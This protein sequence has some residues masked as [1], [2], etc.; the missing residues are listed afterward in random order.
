MKRKGRKRKEKSI[1]GSEG[2]QIERQ[3]VWKG[4]NTERGYPGRERRKE[5]K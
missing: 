3:R 1:V 4:R 2:R 5:E